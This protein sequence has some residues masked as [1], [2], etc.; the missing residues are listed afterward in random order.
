MDMKRRVVLGTMWCVVNSIMWILRISEGFVYLFISIFI[1][2]SY[3]CITPDWKWIFQMPPAKVCMH[4]ESP[5]KLFMFFSFELLWDV[6]ISSSK[7]RFFNRLFCI[8]EGLF[9]CSLKGCLCTPGLLASFHAV[10]VRGCRGCREP[11]G[12][13]IMK[14][15]EEGV[16]RSLAA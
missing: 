4:T 13:G 12:A 3:L 1:T 8:C 6:L 5:I 9:C 2:S 10:S 11:K 7:W 15:C 14:Q 16:C